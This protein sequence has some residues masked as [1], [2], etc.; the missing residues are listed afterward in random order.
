MFAALDHLLAWW[1]RQQQQFRCGWLLL[2]QL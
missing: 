2:L 1:L